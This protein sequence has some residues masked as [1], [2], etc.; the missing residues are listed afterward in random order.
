MRWL[1]RCARWLLL[2]TSLVPLIIDTSVFFPFAFP[3]LVLFRFLVELAFVC[4]AF[5][6][7]AALGKRQSLAALRLPSRAEAWRAV[8]SPLGIAV[9]A[10]LASFIL[11]TL[12]ATDVYRAFWGDVERGGGLIGI[13]H[14]ALFGA[15]LIALFRDREWLWYLRLTVVVG[16]LMCLY[17]AFQYFGITQVPF[18]RPPAERVDSFIGNAA[19]LATHAIFVMAFAWILARWERA[20]TVIRQLSRASAW[21]SLRRY[22]WRWFSYLTLALAAFTVLLTGTRGAMLGLAAGFVVAAVMLLRPGA[23]VGRARTVLMVALGVLALFGAV[24]WVTRTA[25]VWQSVPGFNRLALTQQE[26]LSDTS[27]EV[28]LMTWR[29]AGRSFLEKPVFGWGPEHY[30]TAYERRYDPAF[31]YYGETWLDRAH[32]NL[33][34]IG[35]TQGMLGVISYLALWAVLMALVW[36]SMDGIPR[37]LLIGF[38]VAYFVQNLFLFDQVVSYLTFA[39]LVAWIT[40]RRAALTEESP[41]PVRVRV[42]AFVAAAALGILGLIACYQVNLLPYA[43]AKSYKTSPAL[44]EITKVVEKLKEGMYPYTYAQWNIRG[45]GVDAI[46]QDQYFYYDPYRT[47]QKF[48]TVGET[49]LAGAEEIIARHPAY[50]VRAYI[51]YATLLQAMARDDVAYYGKAA[52]VLERALTLAPNRQELYYLL[53]FSQAGEAKVTE[54]VETARKAVV[55]DTRVARAHFHLALMLDAAGHQDEAKAE[56][57]E[58]ERLD[59]SFQTLLDADFRTLGLLYAGWGDSTHLI[60]LALKSAKGEIPTLREET[61]VS[62]LTHFRDQ[63]DVFNFVTIAK[64]MQKTFPT[65][66]D[67]LEVLIDLANRGEWGI[68]EKL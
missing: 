59:P 22:G 30:I 58:T 64:F 26:S 1:M 44:G 23:L 54:A 57:R 53:A 7:A 37:A 51:R 45:T 36:R 56:L 8:K 38:L 62:A 32:N 46:Y 63:R 31:A 17:A 9:G 43:Q 65:K 34:D 49:I 20:V 67:D 61:Y 15:L 47:N 21:V 41:R 13:L 35:V 60:E 16:F 28:R 14:V 11:S 24:F 55:L 29:I 6:A 4:V 33:I 48:K 3:K 39:A 66:A 42:P 19:F 40:R 18:A 27:T 25:P 50:D 10:Y 12:F 2:A 52:E 68:L 5:A